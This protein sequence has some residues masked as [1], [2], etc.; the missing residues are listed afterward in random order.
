MYSRGSLYN[1]EKLG[2]AR[3]L[4]VLKIL[5]YYLE[6]RQILAISTVSRMENVQNP[7]GS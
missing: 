4:S 6:K 3:A 2:I 1:L 5:R 7:V